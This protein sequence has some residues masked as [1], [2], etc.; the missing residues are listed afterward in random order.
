[1]KKGRRVE[2]G[3]VAAADDEV[4]CRCSMIL[5]EYQK[6]AKRWG[7]KG[8]KRKW[9]TGPSRTTKKFPFHSL[10]WDRR[11]VLVVGKGGSSC[12]MWLLRRKRRSRRFDEEKKAR[13]GP[14]DVGCWYVHTTVLPLLLLRRGLDD[15][16]LF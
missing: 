1:M 3:E 2:K 11:V 13:D 8:E 15:A 5:R 12:G 7:R 6:I 16:R 14:V 4:S 9:N 10:C